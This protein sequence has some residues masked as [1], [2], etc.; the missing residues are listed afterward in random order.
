MEL[1]ILR[2]RT[3]GERITRGLL[4]FV[5]PLSVFVGS[6]KKVD[7]INEESI[8]AAQEGNGEV[9]ILLHGILTK[10]Y[11]GVY[12]AI[13]WFKREG[14]HVVS[15]G[16]DDQA[17][18]EI[19]SKAVKEQIDEILARP[20]ITKLNMVGISLGGGIARYY[21][22]K[23]GGKEVVNRLVT[24]FTP[25]IPPQ[26]N[27]FSMAVMMERIFGNKEIT[28]ASLTQARTVQS[29]FS[30]DQLALYGTSDWIVSTR[31][32]PIN[33]V[34]PK[35]TLIPVS[36]GHTFVSYNTDAMELALQFLLHGK[37]G[38]TAGSE[39]Q[40]FAPLATA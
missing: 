5:Y 31:S 15:L 10:Y 2:K 16:Y 28:E 27:E 12:W 22:E 7:R 26:G 3:L 35:V 30:V 23:L 6:K 11:T 4:R 19:S 14:V 37:A 36:G 40:T 32:Y 33:A 24:I 34:P 21:I 1:P 38:V 20:G 18:L 9:T 8:R 13:K 25:L 17:E 29:L 39:Q